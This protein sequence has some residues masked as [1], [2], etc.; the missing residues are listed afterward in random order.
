M[1]SVFTTSCYIEKKGYLWKHKPL[2]MR[3]DPSIKEPLIQAYP[4]LAVRSK[5]FPDDK[6]LRFYIYLI[7]PD[8]P[9]AQEKD[10]DLRIDKALE[11]CGINRDSEA[12]I[13]FV[14]G[15]E[16]VQDAVFELFRLYASVKYEA[17]FSTKQSF[18]ILNARLRDNYGLKD[19]DRL[20]VMKEID[21]ITE[22]LVKMEYELFKEEHIHDIIAERA[23][24]KSLSGYAEKFAREYIVN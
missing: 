14:E 1:R 20:R 23:A 6:A 15:R 9:L 22:R 2:S 17:W 16:E 18:H 8:S 10:W 5:Y 13:S 12:Y 7:A 3:F 4:P 19:A 21:Q 24:A 11:Y